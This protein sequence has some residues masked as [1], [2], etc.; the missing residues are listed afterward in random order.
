MNLK[1]FYLPLIIGAMGLATS[2][3]SD[4]PVTPGEQLEE[5]TYSTSDDLSII[6]DGTAVT[7]QT[8]TFTPSADGKGTI[9]IAGVMLDLN[10]LIGSIPTKAVMPG[11]PTP[12]MIPGSSSVSIPVELSGDA[13]NCTFSGNGESTYCTFS[14]DG[15]L[16]A[17]KL[18]LSISELKLKNTSIAGTYAAPENIY[19]TDSRGDQQVALNK[20]MRIIWEA[21]ST[22]EVA[23][24]WSLPV[25]TI[26]PLTMMMV[27]LPDADGNKQQLPTLL[28]EVLKEVTF[29]EDGSVT[30]KYADT[31]QE[32]WPAVTS[33]KGFAQYVVK[34]DG[35]LLL[36]LNPQS[37][38]ASALPGLNGSTKAIDPSAI[39]EGLLTTVVPMISNGIPVRYGKCLAL[40]EEGQIIYNEDGAPTFDTDSSNVSFYLDNETL[41]PILKLAAPIISDDDIINSIVEIAQKDP[42]MGSMAESLPGILKS[43]PGVI[44]T[45]T[46]IQLGLNLVK[47]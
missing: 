2:C 39:V 16:T 19:I 14:Y 41:L 1:L 29:G 17:D 12:S 33:P 15:T 42:I 6:L 21:D 38:I 45:T 27:T 31:K 37:I 43:L 36:F 46:D 34:E 5:K 23:P 25:K 32:G 13:N 20:V 3:K 10:D 11:I 26:L 40:D 35:T 47:K 7:G 24:G 44:D 28:N 4:D 9:T 8:V 18:S 30:A 22:I